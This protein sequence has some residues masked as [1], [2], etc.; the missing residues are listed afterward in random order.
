MPDEGAFVRWGLAHWALIAMTL[1]LPVVLGWWSRRQPSGG[2]ER[3]VGHGLTGLLLLTWMASLRISLREHGGDWAA[4]LPMHLCDWAVAAVVLALLTRRQLAF[5]LAYF[6]GLA[7]TIQG[8]LTPDLVFGFPHP[9]C[10][11]FFAAHCGIV[12][13]VLFLVLGGGMRPRPGSVWRTLLWT[14]LYGGSAFAVNLALGTN[15][16]YTLRKPLQPSLLDHLGPWPWYLVSLQALALALFFL[17][18]LPF[19]VGRGRAIRRP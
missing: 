13:G 14:N 12:V 9:R 15:Y 4:S 5:E 1:V 10:V 2:F 7:G 6:W 19:R 17:L 18:D 8:I 3:T 16:G 11:L